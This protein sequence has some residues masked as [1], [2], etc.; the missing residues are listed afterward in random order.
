MRVFDPHIRLDEIYGSNRNF[1]LSAV[2]HIRRLLTPGLGELLDG[3]THVVLAQKPSPET[4]GRMRV[5]GA[6]IIDLIGFLERSAGAAPA[7]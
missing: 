6:E 3:A 5:S 4:L 7:S 1:I 2:P